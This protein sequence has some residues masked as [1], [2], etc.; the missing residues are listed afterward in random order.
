MREPSFSSRHVRGFL[1]GA[2]ER[3]FDPD[4]LLRLAGVPRRSFHDEDARIDGEQYSR[5]LT[6][7]EHQMDDAFMGFTS[8][9]ARLT[10]YRE[11]SRARFRCE[12]L[13]EA[14]KVS[15][16]FREAVRD[17]V[18]YQ[19][20]S[21]RRNHSFTLT[22][23]YRLRPGADEVVFYIHRLMLMYKYFS[24]L[25]GRRLRLSAVYF[26]FPEPDPEDG[27][28]FEGW[29]GC[30]AHFNQSANALSF[31]NTHLRSPIVRTEA[32]QADFQDRYPN[33]FTIPGE[34]RS[35]TGRV[36]K[37]LVVLQ[38]EG[39]WCP[40]IS[41]VARAL[42]ISGR[43]LRRQ[44]AREGTNFQ[45]IKARL[46]KE[47][48]IQLLV[49]TDLPVTLVSAEIGFAEPGD[50]T[51][52]FRGWMDCTPSSYRRRFATDKTVL[53]SLRATVSRAESGAASSY[54]I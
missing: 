16:Q 49:M 45:G 54:L 1:Q 4:E 41:R 48:A 50:F 26:A 33:W 15:T 28:D 17:D 31:D 35:W 3:G 11:Q 12:T 19:Y 52:A 13:G 37:E 44:L 2:I 34:D 20:I 51:R 23:D 9:R 10:M 8:H 7:I 27:I 30:E 25:I 22:V 18:T 29:F 24:W 47:A 36:E 6:V 40:T 21:D 5:L 46:R 53:G 42:K 39:D 38:R 43:A 32:E 14:I